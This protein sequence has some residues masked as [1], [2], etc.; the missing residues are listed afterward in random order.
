MAFESRSAKQS[1]FVLENSFG[2][3]KRIVLSAI[4]STM[5]HKS[6]RL[7][8][9]IQTPKYLRF[10]LY[11]GSFMTISAIGSQKGPI[12]RLPG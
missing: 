4:T 2:I 5:I 11:V 12:E 7:S 1:C 10:V 9:W 3:S 6:V 8:T